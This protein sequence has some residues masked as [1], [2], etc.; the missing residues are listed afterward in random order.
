MDAPI[1]AFWRPD[2]GGPTGMLESV[3]FHL[4]HRIDLSGVGPEGGPAVAS[5]VSRVTA[6]AK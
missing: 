4:C 3:D 1:I 6:L 5:D 2:H